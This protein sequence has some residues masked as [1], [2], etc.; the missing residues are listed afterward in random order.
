LG[1]TKPVEIE[2]KI[3]I[4]GLGSIGQNHVSC[5]KKIGIHDIVALR[6][7]RGLKELPKDFDYINQVYNED[8][9]Y[10]ERPDGVI[11]SNP[12]ALHVQSMIEPLKKNLSIFVEKPIS[13]S[14]ADLKKIE[15]YDK[16]KILVGY[17]FRHNKII[18]EVK[19]VIISGKLGKIIKANFYCGQ[20]LPLWHTYTDYNKEYYARKDLGGGA[21]RTL[22]HEID[23]SN[24]L[25]GMPTEILANVSKISDL[26]I[27]VDDSAQLI[28]RNKQD[29]TISIELDYLNPLGER[30]GS[31]FGSKGYLKYS[32]SD[33]KIVFSNLQGKIEIIYD[34][35]NLKFEDMY[36]RQ[37]KH[38]IRLVNGKE[39]SECTFYDGINVLRIITAAERSSNSNRVWK[40]IEKM[41]G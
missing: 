13:E 8:D 20:Y 19:D 32:L 25:V 35:P 38:F 23:I 33:S 40:K 36:L 1:K 6:T 14:L 10:N 31:I 7:K 15:K 3:G 11:I 28:C 39:K 41:R 17:C 4:I 21:I 30:H 29:T 12:T 26:K 5:L 24:F 18:N 9:F 16:S 27:D 37:M 22:S 34:N 2:M